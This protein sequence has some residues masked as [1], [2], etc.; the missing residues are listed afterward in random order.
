M[1]KT[2]TFWVLVA[3]CRDL[4]PVLS[5]LVSGNT[6]LNETH[7][8]VR[9]RDSD[10]F[11]DG[12][13]LVPCRVNFKCNPST[14]TCLAQDILTHLKRS[15]DYQIVET[16]D[17]SESLKCSP[18]DPDQDAENGRMLCEILAATRATQ[19]TFGHSLGNTWETCPTSHHGIIDGCSFNTSAGWRVQ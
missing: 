2:V 16:V 17:A 6:C 10:P 19:P 5:E 14:G 4:P 8:L 11:Q 7:V 18:V 3:F 9:R 13:L 12:E 15:V 1:H